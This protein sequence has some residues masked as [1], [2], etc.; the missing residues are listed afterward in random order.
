MLLLELV[1]ETEELDEVSLMELELEVPDTELELDE[2]VPETEL[3]DVVSL[4]EIELVSLILEEE[5]VSL[6]ELLD[7]VPV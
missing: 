4:I 6:I 5:D 7:V 1:C 3:L 2:L